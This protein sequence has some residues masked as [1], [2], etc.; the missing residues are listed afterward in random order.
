MQSSLGQTVVPNWTREFENAELYF[1]NSIEN[2]EYEERFEGEREEWMHLA[3][4]CQNET[5]VSNENVRSDLEYWLLPD[6][7]IL[8]NKLEICLLGLIE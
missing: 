7:N 1:E 6:K 3:D 5:N 4:L 2:D 8:K